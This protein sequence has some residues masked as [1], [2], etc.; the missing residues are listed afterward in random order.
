MSAVEILPPRPRKQPKRPYHILNLSVD[1]DGCGVTVDL[2]VPPC[3]TPPGPPGAWPARDIVAHVQWE[4]RQLLAQPSAGL[5]SIDPAVNPAMVVDDEGE[6]VAYDPR[7]SVLPLVVECRVQPPEDSLYHTPEGYRA[8]LL[9]DEHYPAKPPEINFMQTLHHFFL[10][11]DNDLPSIFYELLTDLVADL[12]EEGEPTQHTLRATLQLLAHVLQS[13]LHPC[14]GC[15]Q[16][17]DAY[18]RMH[19]E[20]QQTILDY[21]PHRGTPALFACETGWRAEWLHPA[22]RAALYGAHDGASEASWDGDEAAREARLAALL[23]RCV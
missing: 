2:D 8:R 1:A 12:V 10:G 9:I 6:A 15:Q 14:E 4:V 20:R 11:N 7:V 16:Q 23:T 21:V 22:L 3:L 18:A 19:A 5:V 17:F 13:P